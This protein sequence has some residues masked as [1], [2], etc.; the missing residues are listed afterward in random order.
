M[1]QALRRSER[2]QKIQQEMDHAALELT[3]IALFEPVEN[4][5]VDLDFAL[6][7]EISEHAVPHQ[8]G[9]LSD[10]LFLQVEY[11]LCALLGQL[12]HVHGGPIQ[13]FRDHGLS[14]H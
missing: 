5:L 9:V 7:N 14:P 8:L 1:N 6:L 4:I 11:D 10:L 3:A 2:P 13:N 12:I